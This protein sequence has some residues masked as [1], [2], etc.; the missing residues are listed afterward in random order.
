M[1]VVKVNWSGGKDSTAAL[2]MHYILGD[3]VKAVCY[4]PMFND[5]IPLITKDHYNFII[6][7][8]KTFRCLG[9]SVNIV[10]GMTY[11]DY[12][13]RE[14]SRGKNKGKI[15][16]FPCF[17]PQA[18]NFRNYSKL[19]ALN[20]IDIGAY[21]YEDIGIAYDEVKRQNQL[22]VSKRSI[23]VELRLT[24]EDAYKICKENNLL[25]PHY[26]I[27][28]RDGCAL[29]PNGSK[30]VREKWFSDYPMAIEQVKELQSYISANRP[31]SYP[32]RDKR[33]FIEADGTIN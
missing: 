31:E 4:I 26:K 23:L 15:F 20:S 24:E 5:T 29:C 16:G 12:V 28:K 3:T 10:H 25:S 22:T 18:C 32:L 19:K 7:T 17:I 30:K 9:V 27:A 6:D 11:T 33:F 14:I 21:D 1:S 2:Y 13:C 8:A